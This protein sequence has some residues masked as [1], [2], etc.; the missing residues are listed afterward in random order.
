VEEG[1]LEASPVAKVKKPAYTPRD[2]II[3]QEQ[4]KALVCAVK[5]RPYSQGFLDFLMLLRNTG[6]RP[7]EARTAEARHLDRKGRCLVFERHESKGH[8]GERTTERRVVPLTDE[9]F[10]LCVR[11]ALKNPAGPLLRTKAGT[12][13]NRR[14]IIKWFRRLEGKEKKR[15]TKAPSRSKYTV[16][17]FSVTAYM[18]RHTWATEAIERGVDLI[19]VATIMGHKDLTQLMK[20]YQHMN[21]KGEHL[22]R[23]LYQAVGQTIEQAVDR[24]A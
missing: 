24:P 13:F 15:K 17:D 14:S 6:C 21:K 16:L 1:H 12:P 4:W 19:T 5:E 8:G 11:L 23:A 20:T 7:I 18:L 3:T 9:V 2:A 22:R 10:D